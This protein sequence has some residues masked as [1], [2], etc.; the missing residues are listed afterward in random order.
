MI[1]RIVL[2][3][4]SEEFT[5]DEALAEVAER[6]REVLPALPGVLECHVGL[7]ADE[8]TT[9]SWH[10]VLV[11]RFASADAIPPYAAHPD[12]RAYVDEFLRPRLAS[13][14]AHNFEI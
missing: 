14:A 12:H 6:S 11:L 9:A 4:M 2:L 7:A 8:S 5:S 3:R 1:E 10:V 13:I